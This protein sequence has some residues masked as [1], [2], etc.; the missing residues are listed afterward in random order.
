[1]PEDFARIYREYYPRL[2]RYLTSLCGDAD[3]VQDIAQDTFVQAFKNLDSFEGRASFQTWLFAI[4]RHELARHYRKNPAA[5]LTAVSAD[6]AAH[7]A[8]SADHAD[9][10]VA[11]SVETQAINNVLAGQV[12][13]LIDALSEPTRTIVRLRLV[14]EMS[15]RDISQRVCRSEVSCRV[16]VFRVKQRIRR[17]CL[18]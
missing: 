8:G 6:N 5:L 17:E 9:T 13:R 1:L 2:V 15:F 11:A 3:C 18:Q 10:K 16:A 14:Q 12:A 7:L 4:G